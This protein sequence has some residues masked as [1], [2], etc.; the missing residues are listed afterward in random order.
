M[1]ATHSH[2]QGESHTVSTIATPPSTTTFTPTPT[3]RIV[4]RDPI[5]GALWTRGEDGAAHWAADLPDTAALAVQ[6]FPGPDPR[7]PAP[8]RR[9]PGRTA[10]AGR[11]MRPRAPRSSR[12]VMA[13]VATVWVAALV[14]SGLAALGHLL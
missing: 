4:Y 7:D 12:H 3:A 11:H 8:A 14:L 13:V 2:H 1:M 9:I 10:P 5:T 6:S